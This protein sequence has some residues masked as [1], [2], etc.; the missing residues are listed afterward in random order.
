VHLFSEI[1]DRL[2]AEAN[3]LELLG[4]AVD[5]DRWR[6]EPLAH[7]EIVLEAL[8]TDAPLYFQ[9]CTRYNLV[10]TLIQR[11]ADD[12]LRIYHSKEPEATIEG[13]QRMRLLNLIATL[14]D[15]P[16]DEDLA[17]AARMQNYLLSAQAVEFARAIDFGIPFHL[18]LSK[19]LAEISTSRKL[20][21]PDNPPEARCSNLVGVAFSGGGIRS[22]T[23]NLGLLQGM[24][25]LGLLRRF[26]YLSTV[27]GGGYIGSW[28][29]GWIRHTDLDQVEKF[30]A[31][32]E[33]PAAGEKPIRW[34]REYLDPNAPQREPIQILREYSNY[35]TPE[36]GFFSADTWTMIAVFL[37]NTLLNQMV[38]ALTLGALLM[39]PYLVVPSDLLL[40]NPAP[41]VPRLAALV[42]ALSLLLGVWNIGRN[43]QSF[44]PLLK[45][46][47][48]EDQDQVITRVVLPVFVA[49]YAASIS[50]F[51]AHLNQA[52][53]LAVYAGIALFIFACFAVLQYAGRLDRCFFDCVNPEDRQQQAVKAWTWLLGTAVCSALVGTALIRC[54]VAIMSGWIPYHAPWSLISFGVPLTVGAFALMVVFEIGLLG[55]NFPDERREWWSRLGAWLFIFSLSW[56]ALFTISLYGP[57]MVEIGWKK[58][59]SLTFTWV[60]STL[61]R[62]VGRHQFEDGPDYRGRQSARS[63]SSPSSLPAPRRLSSSSASFWASAS[64]FRRC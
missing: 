28:L 25:A 55:R 30:L 49:A 34:E 18:V 26:D 1:A 63:P 27:S 24:S 2:L 13:R 45:K 10:P 22:A 35:L 51:T 16:T 60:I 38:L 4:D 48:G 17:S 54:L 37:R 53:S 31:P 23:L 61:G 9:L 64:A 11:L 21:M 7:H 12:V 42:A 8:Y 41:L 47:K 5:Q 19:E 43:L 6:R 56:T 15:K 40:G 44:E 32:P 52:L 36:L 46:S 62:P 3:P 39:L 50:L 59:S 29:A 14:P 33:R 20:R 57:R 58:L